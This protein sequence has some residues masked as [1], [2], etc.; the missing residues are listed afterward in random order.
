MTTLTINTYGQ[1]LCALIVASLTNRKHF[2]PIRLQELADNIKARQV[3]QPIIIRMLPGHRMAETFDAHTGAYV[4]TSAPKPIYEI[5]A[6]E[7][8]AVAA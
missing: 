6:G 8:E 5:V 4:G 1:C 3:D 2:D 7:L